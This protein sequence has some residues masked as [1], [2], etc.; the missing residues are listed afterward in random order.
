MNLLKFRWRSNLL[1]TVMEMLCLLFEVVS[2]HQ[3]Y[4]QSNWKAPQRA[5]NLKKLIPVIS[6]QSQPGKTLY[7]QFCVIC[8]SDNGK[9]DG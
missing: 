7:K 4:G 9:G 5:N 6:P 1:Q 3:I 2:G 8:H